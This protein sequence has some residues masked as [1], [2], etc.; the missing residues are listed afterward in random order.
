MSGDVSFELLEDA[1]ADPFAALAE[2]GEHLTR[3]RAVLPPR[4]AETGPDADAGDGPGLA[5]VLDVAQAAVAS[6]A[7]FAG[8]L[9]RAGADGGIVLV[10]EGR[11]V[12]VVVLGTPT[13]AEVA[14]FTSALAALGRRFLDAAA[15]LGL[16][17]HLATAWAAA[18]FAPPV[19]LKSLEDGGP[20]ILALG[21][22]LLD[23][24][25]TPPPP[26]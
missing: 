21:A 17:L 25:A 2:L 22:G 11:R 14:A 23:A 18:G 15:L 3:A 1:D 5:Q 26:A 6:F 8:G 10:R 4:A 7:D 13:P 24:S 19:V 16:L 20:R 9:Q 12:T